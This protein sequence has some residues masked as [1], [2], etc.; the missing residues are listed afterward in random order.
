MLLLTEQNLHGTGLK[1]GSES[2]EEWW[3][4]WEEKD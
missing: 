1:V 2:W 3:D 4:K